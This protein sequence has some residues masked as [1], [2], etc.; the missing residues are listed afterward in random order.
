[1]IEYTERTKQILASLTLEE[2]AQLISGG[3]DFWH[4]RAI[5]RLGIPALALHDGPHGLRRIM[6]KENSSGLDTS[7]PA[8]SYPSLSAV[9]CSF[10][11][12]LVFELGESLGAEAKAAG[13]DV[14]LAPGVNIKRHP[15]NGR[16]FEYFSE[17]P[18]LAGE[19]ASAYIRGVQSQGT[20]AC[21]K[22]FSANN[23]EFCRMINNCHRFESARLPQ[24]I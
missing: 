18:L 24:A 1:M 9:A 6:P 3:G 15:L 19:L 4:T 14:L 22:H 10:D 11:R 12:D 20:A 21:L 2:K 8:T 16:N 23:Q 17:D 13:V 5:P 7:V